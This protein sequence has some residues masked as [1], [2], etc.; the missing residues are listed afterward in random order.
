VLSLPLLLGLSMV[1]IAGASFATGAWLLL[2]P[3]RTR[4]DRLGQYTGGVDT[5]V[6][7]PVHSV[8][9]LSELAERLSS[10]AA[11]RDQ[12][13]VDKQRRRLLQ[14]G[15]RAPS[16][17]AWFNLSRVVLA[18]A[19]PLL[20]SLQLPSMALAPASFLVLV[21]AF[22]G[23]YLPH[24]VV[25]HLAAKRS[26]AIMRVFPDALD[27]LVTSTE[28]GLGLDAALRR[29]AEEMELA[30]PVL[31]LELQIV[32]HEIAAG[33]PRARALRRLADRVD[34]EAVHSLVN[35]LVQAEK[36]GTSV[37]RALRVHAGLVRQRR[38]LAAEERA[39]RIA[40]KMTVAMVFFLL[41]TLFVV[42]LGPAVV[43]LIRNL[44]PAL[45]G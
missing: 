10:L 44:M 1:L 4:R 3:V 9:K 25:E 33:I 21:M 30:A 22:V 32:V 45:A 15:L 16:A 28:A 29:V 41:P 5:L 20:G 34:L 36:L 39:A 13:E 14:A 27:L 24:R 42:I 17:L 8:S 38:I 18:L 40:P 6:Q 37:A 19:L 43:N 35:V 2:H 31:A 23:Y 26:E 11:E 7:A 12:D